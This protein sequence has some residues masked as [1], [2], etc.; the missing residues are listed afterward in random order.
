M[1][2]LRKSR[3]NLAVGTV[4][5][6]AALMPAASFGWS[7]DTGA[8][9]L[10]TASGGDTLL[11]PIYSTVNPATTS[12]SVTNTSGSQT[13]AAKIRFREQEKSMDVLD[14]IVIF[15]PYDKFDFSVSQGPEDARPTMSWNDNTCLVGPGPGGSVQFP[16]PSAFVSGDST[17][18]VGHLEVLGM[19]DLSGAYV[20][21]NG[22][23]FLADGITPVT[24]TTTGAISLGAAAKHGPDGVPAN[25][26]ILTTVLASQAN[27][28]ALNAAGALLDVDNVLMG[29]YVITGAGLGIEAGGDAIGI[30]DSNLGYPAMNISAQSNSECERSTNCVANYAWDL[31]EWDHPHLG[32][33][34]NL[35]GFQLALTAS[36]ISGD[37]SNNPANFVG[38]DWVLSFPNKY[39]YLDL[40]S[41]NSTINTC[42]SA[43]PV[44]SPTWCL[45]NATRTGF[46][47][48]GI[49][50]GNEAGSPNLCLTDSGLGVWDREEQQ[51]SGNVTVSPGG[52]TTL[53]ICNELQ[54]FTVAAAGTEVRPS[55]IQTAERRGV[56]TFEN[57]DAIRGWARMTMPWATVPGDSVSGVLFT[58]RNT[59]DPTINN[60][61]LTDLQ[62]DAGGVTGQ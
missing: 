26:G 19:A 50:T 51:A 42:G 22:S 2:K 10:N 32:E 8:G 36:S 13:I 33:M 61:S 27:V 40:V 28:A 20:L 29:R 48:P 53:D 43:T 41:P 16:P 55:V 24:Q 31:R 12:F 54:I 60:A 14:F 59:D 21:A 35:S 44:T 46:G 23:A 34:A 11:F 56:V 1:M 45:L 4:L 62:K 15:S 17:M 25:C 58:T 6:A 38:V 37:W 18:S 7:V 47:T 49:W 52:R 39:A 57:L 9:V 3:L 5:G 30:R